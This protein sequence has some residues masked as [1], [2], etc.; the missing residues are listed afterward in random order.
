MRAGHSPHTDRDN[1]ADTTVLIVR[2]F[3]NHYGISTSRSNGYIFSHTQAAIIVLVSGVEG[4][5]REAVGMLWVR[6]ES[7]DRY[8]GYGVEV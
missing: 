4:S 8:C 7:G 5:V 6:E 2:H 3:S 1:L